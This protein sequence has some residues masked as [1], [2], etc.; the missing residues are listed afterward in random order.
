MVGCWQWRWQW[1]CCT[2]SSTTCCSRATKSGYHVGEWI[3]ECPV[4]GC[5]LKVTCSLRPCD[6][7]GLLPF[8]TDSQ[9]LERVRKSLVMCLSSR[10]RRGHESSYLGPPAFSDSIV[11]ILPDA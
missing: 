11:L 5:A 4:A 7:E 1:I 6:R 9:K 2:A 3:V 10:H 8:H